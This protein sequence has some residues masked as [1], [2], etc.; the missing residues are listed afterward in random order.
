MF[1]FLPPSSRLRRFKLTFGR[2]LHQCARSPNA[3]GEADF[4][5]IHVA[6]QGF[7]RSVAAARDYV[8]DAFRDAASTQTSASFKAVNGVSSDGFSTTE[9][10]QAS[11]GAS[12]QVAMHVG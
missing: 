10:P 2:C 7:P 8:D 12:F 4:V 9:H 6:A 5:H 3:S 11:A 1:G